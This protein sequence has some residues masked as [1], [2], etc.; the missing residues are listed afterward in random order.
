MT[1]RLVLFVA[2]LGAAACFA[3]E[4]GNPFTTKTPRP[5]SAEKAGSPAS[6]I[7]F[8]ILAPIQRGLNESL[9]AMTRSLHD[10]RSPAGWLLVI[11]L[12]ALYGAFHAAGPGHG[13]TIV[14]S[15]LLANQARLRHAVIVGY[16]IA[17]VHVV[18][19]LAVVLVL[20]FIVRGVFAVGLANA[21]RVIQTV[22]F[23]AVAVIGGFMLVGRI[24]GAVHHHHHD[25]GPAPAPGQVTFAKLFAIAVPAGMIP[26]PGAV[27]VILF[28]L[29]LNML[30]ASLVSVIS[31]SVGM[32][33]TISLA[34]VLALLA[35]SGA[36]SILGHGEE[37]RISRVRRVI[38]IAGTA[39]V[40]LIGTA[41][42]V[43]QF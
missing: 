42:L 33:A 15:Y 12:S 34:A 35:K 1:K 18:A 38:E 36:A 30:G 40:F 16:L 8:A 32:G 3:Q 21:N 27:A 26:C 28:A 24:R 17:A 5:P 39:A 31:M 29:S 23:A 7:L 22:S 43:A 6:S 20:S 19:A 2:L 13:K 37:E 25:H 14:S 41:F 9:A 4:T 10:A 11:G